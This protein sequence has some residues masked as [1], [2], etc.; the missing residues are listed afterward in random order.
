MFPFSDWTTCLTSVCVHVGFQDG[1]AVTY[2]FLNCALLPWHWEPSAI[3]PC[4]IP[5][6]YFLWS[7]SCKFWPAA[8][9]TE[10]LLAPAFRSNLVEHDTTT[11]SL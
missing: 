8:F 9:N 3:V 2:T 6:G 11:T 7:S 1:N 5:S 10:R 4:S